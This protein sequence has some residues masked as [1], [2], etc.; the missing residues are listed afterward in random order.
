[1]PLGINGIVGGCPKRAW[2]KDFHQ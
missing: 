2:K 1:M